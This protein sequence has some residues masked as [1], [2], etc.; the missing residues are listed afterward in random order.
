[1][2]VQDAPGAAHLLGAIADTLEQKVLPETGPGARHQVRVAANLCRI[3]ARELELDPA[4][5]DRARVAL[6]VLLGHGGDTDDLWREL[7]QELTPASAVLTATTATETDEL[8]RDAHA[9][10]LAIVRDK[11]A[12]AKPGYDSDDLTDEPR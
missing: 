8:A 11:L 4:A 2:A 5:D 3:V 9:V 12:V 7:A 1:M 10:A 6:S